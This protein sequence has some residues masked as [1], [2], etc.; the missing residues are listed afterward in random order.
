[1]CNFV[2]ELKEL[3]KK[4]ALRKTKN[5]NYFSLALKNKKKE[6]GLL[7]QN[8]WKSYKKYERC[9]TFTSQKTSGIL[10]CKTSVGLKLPPNWTYLKVLQLT[11]MSNR[12]LSSIPQNTWPFA[13]FLWVGLVPPSPADSVISIF[14]KKRFNWLDIQFVL[15]LGPF[16]QVLQ[17]IRILFFCTAGRLKDGQSFLIGMTSVISSV[18]NIIYLQDLCALR[19]HRKFHSWFMTGRSW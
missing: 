11:C 19:L 14:F 6:F 5:I 1:M 16:W 18:L 8:N 3:K 10:E 12:S 4:C 13:L 7:D 2:G 17:N 9:L 15:P